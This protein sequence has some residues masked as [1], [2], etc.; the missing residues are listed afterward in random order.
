MNDTHI[1]SATCEKF[2]E[3]EKTIINKNKRFFASNLKYISDMLNIINGNSIISIRIIEYFIVNYSIKYN[4]FYTISSNGHKSLFYVNR[5]YKNQLNGYSKKYFDFFCRHKKIKYTFIDSKKK[6]ITFLSSIGQINFFQWA[7][8]Y[9]IIKYITFHLAEIEYAM[10]KNC[11]K[12]K[13]N[14]EIKRLLKN[15]EQLEIKKPQ[16]GVVIKGDGSSIYGSKK[17]PLDEI[18]LN[19]S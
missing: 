7:I 12:N 18:K 3:Q 1:E 19:F 13:Q 17:K 8:R 10:K 11:K 16:E 5:E 15:K 6:K 14:R 9:K 2:T 4:T